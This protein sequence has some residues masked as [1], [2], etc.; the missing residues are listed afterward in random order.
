MTL[1]EAMEQAKDGQIIKRNYQISNGMTF[2]M[3]G[4]MKVTE[5]GKF[6]AAGEMPYWGPLKLTDLQADN[7]EVTQ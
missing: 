3:W 6:L 5:Y 2:T 7:W 1:I 4:V